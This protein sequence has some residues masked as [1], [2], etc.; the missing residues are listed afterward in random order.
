MTAFFVPAPPCYGK[1]AKRSRPLPN[2]LAYLMLAIWPLVA[3]GLFARLD[4]VRALIWGT[5]LPFLLLPPVA[6][7]D[8]PGLPDLDK[9]N[10]A[11]L[12]LLVLVL[13]QMKARPEFVPKSW[14]LRGLMVLFV[15]SP[16]ATVLTNPEGYVV[17][18]R[19]FP[20]QR[21]YDSISFLAY[22]ALAVVPFFLGRHFLARPDTVPVLL[23]AIVV[24]CLAYSLPM[25]VEVRLSPQINVWI[26]GFFQHDFLQMIRRGG[27]RPIVFLPHGL[28]AAFFTMM[29]VV[30]A[31]VMLRQAAPDRRP[32]WLLAFLWLA[33]VLVLTK[34]LGAQAMALALVPAVLILPPRPMVLIAGGVAAMV[35]TYPLLRGA[36]LIAVGDIIALV[37]RIDPARAQSFAF[38]IGNEE[39]LLDRAQIKPW[40]GWG[41]YARNLIHDPDTGRLL[42]VPDGNW[43][44][45]LGI[46][47]W[48]GYLAQFGLLVLPLLRLGR[49]A[50]ARRPGIELP[51]A[52]LALI[53]AANLV[54]LLPNATLMTLTWL[55]AGALT[56]QA[57]TLAATR[58]APAAAPPA[59]PRTIL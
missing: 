32:G 18:G 55:I 52:G 29:A 6:R 58:A 40:F 7:F 10:I 12:T 25:L 24:A 44:I 34:T 30:S 53:Y 17:G 56:G 51:V 8:L 31:A 49:L 5:I 15:F 50:L 45:V 54:E 13:V 43:I 9:A 21:I 36:G 48:T 2:A 41:G 3:V 28:W 59:R 14:L 23:G 16:F 1:A 4:P 39:A 37:E 26:Y 22:Q 33:M 42:T 57:E 38:R 47:G 46:F 27:F 11:N 19:L 20:G 35:I